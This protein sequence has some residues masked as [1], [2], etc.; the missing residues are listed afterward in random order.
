MH[1]HLCPDEIGAAAHVLNYLSMCG[2]W[3]WLRL[4]QW[5]RR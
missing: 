1:I 5:L 4:A 3:L 2:G